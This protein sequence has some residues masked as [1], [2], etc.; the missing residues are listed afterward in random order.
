MVT[1]TNKVYVF[2]DLSGEWDTCK[3]KEPIETYVSMGWRGGL[4]VK[5]IGHPSRGPGLDSQCPHWVLQPPVI[6][7]SRDLASSSGCHKHQT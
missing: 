5:D 3:V 6:P 7:V 4:A 1:P 2:I